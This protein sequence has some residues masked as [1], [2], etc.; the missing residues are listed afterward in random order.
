MGDDINRKLVISNNE[1]IKNTRMFMKN[2]VI[3]WNHDTKILPIGKVEKIEDGMA[4]CRFLSLQRFQELIE[5][6][7]SSTDLEAAIDSEGS[8]LELSLVNKMD[9]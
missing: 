3:L 7:I 6:G 4:T 8:L 9:Q 1:D 2:P 5:L